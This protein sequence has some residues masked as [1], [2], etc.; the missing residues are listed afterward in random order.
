MGN[1]SHMGVELVAVLVSVAVLFGAATQRITGMGFA[2]VSSPAL[3]LLLGTALAVPLIQVAG[4]PLSLLVLI[5]TYR[6]VS[7]RKAVALGIPALFGLVPG[8]LL[9]RA[10]S[11]PVLRIIIGLMILTALLTMLADERAR[12][13]KGTPGLIG[14]GFLSGFMQIL[15]GVGGP[16]IVLYKL[17]TDWLHREFVATIQVYFISLS[18]GAIV[19]LGWPDLAPSVWVAALTGIGVG[20]LLGQ[21]LARW[22]PVEV[23]SRLVIVVALAGAVATIAQGLLT[24]LS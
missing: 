24:L 3:V 13:F 15:A 16:A 19:A 20:L 9:A 2:L 11:E 14:A 12:V 23:A 18:L 4:I 6:D 7:W 8:W 17:S 1:T 5:S 21:L 22:I 10:V